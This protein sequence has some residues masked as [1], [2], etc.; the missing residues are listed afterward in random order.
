[1]VF[2]NDCGKVKA[3]LASGLW[4]IAGRDGQATLLAALGML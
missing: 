1:M 2:R 3:A 4:R